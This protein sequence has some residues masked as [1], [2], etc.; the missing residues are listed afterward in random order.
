MKQ[1]CFFTLSIWLWKW[2]FYLSA[3]PVG[4]GSAGTILAA[5]LAEDKHSVLLLEAGGIAPFFLDIPLLGPLIQNTVYDWQYVTVS[6]EYACKGLINNVNVLACLPEH[7]NIHIVIKIFFTA[8]QM[9]QGQNS[10]RFKPPKLYGLCIG[11]STGLRRMV[12]RFY[13]Y[14]RSMYTNLYKVRR[15]I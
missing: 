7:F 11:T 13:W 1:N 6:Q 3:I 10:R 15:Y 8:K 2:F 4:A 14:T 12:S 5:H 9:A